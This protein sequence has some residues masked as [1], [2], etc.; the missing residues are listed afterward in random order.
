MRSS[1]T[2]QEGE[3][4]REP[5][6][7]PSRQHIDTGSSCLYHGVWLLS[8]DGTAGRTDTKGR[9]R[10]MVPCARRLSVG[11]L[12]AHPYRIANEKPAHNGNRARFIIPCDDCACAEQGA[13]RN[14][15]ETRRF[16]A[17]HAPS[18]VQRLPLDHCVCDQALRQLANGD[19]AI[20]FMTGGDHEPRKDNYI[21]VCR[22]ATAATPA[23][24]RRLSLGSPTKRAC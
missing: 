5:L 17:R 4:T 21:A 13:Y 9:S 24:A 10:T 3:R 23:L 19:W 14:I 20:F 7:G 18:C 6:R 12:A 2:P 15:N 1:A 16:R 11:A 8:R 22:S